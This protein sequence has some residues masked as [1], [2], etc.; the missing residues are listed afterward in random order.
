MKKI[1]VTIAVVALLGSCKKEDEK[2]T[3]NILNDAYQEHVQ[4]FSMAV[5]LSEEQMEEIIKK[6][7]KLK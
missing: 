4:R 6:Y 2:D 7:E 5:P 3:D 1:V